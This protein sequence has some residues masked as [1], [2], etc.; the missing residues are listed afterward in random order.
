[1]EKKN[2]FGLCPYVTLQKVLTG[3]WSMYIMH[4]LTDGPI[5]I[6]LCIKH[7]CHWWTTRICETVS[8]W[9]CLITE[10]SILII[11]SIF[12]FLIWFSFLLKL[13][14]FPLFSIIQF[15]IVSYYY[16][17]KINYRYFAITF[18]SFC[19]KWR[20]VSLALYISR[21]TSITF[22]ITT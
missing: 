18:L 14:S 22:L 13:K 8:W 3:K 6:R 16:F 4:L 19:Y 9:E 15:C 10:S 5:R 21:L 20:S 1:M 12:S 17:S 2:L 7:T 11:L